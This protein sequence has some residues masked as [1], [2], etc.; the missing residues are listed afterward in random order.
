VARRAASCKDR[1][2]SWRE[3]ETDDGS[4]TLQ[5]TS[6][7][8]TCHSTAG[9]WTQARER[10]ARA[11]RIAELGAERGEVALLDIGTG[12]GLNLA[13]ALEAL[14][15]SA[16]RLEAVSFERDADLLAR[17]LELRQARPECERW[18]APARD[19]LRAA[20]ER[21]GE[22]VATAWGGLRLELGDART[23]VQRWSS[24]TFDAVFL[25]PFAPSVEPQL[26]SATFLADLAAAM[27]PHAVLSTYSASAAVRTG[28]LAAGLRVGQGPRVGR[29][30]Q[31]SLASFTTA[32]P[33]LH[34][35]LERKLA[36]RAAR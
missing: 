13:A 11:C 36:R 32:L 21:P 17:A 12:L 27:A 33:P 15:V 30:A 4:C 20:L 26:W 5:R 24:G 28:L 3:L 16:A 29:K 34:P 23:R 6:D 22:R 1:S 19:A 31:G 2:V 18:A 10:Y 35:R 9:A 8:V 25:D 7:A 14:A